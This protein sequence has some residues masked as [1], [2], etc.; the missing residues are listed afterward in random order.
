MPPS[1]SSDAEFH[2]AE[3]DGPLD[4]MDDAA[5]VALLE[6]LNA[7]DLYRTKRG[8]IVGSHRQT[9]E[10]YGSGGGRTPIP[11]RALNYLIERRIPMRR[12]WDGK[13]ECED[14]SCYSDSEFCSDG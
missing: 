13:W 3:N 14:G 11:P 9:G 4:E 7:L 6:L 5:G 12:E 8:E 1:P 2:D 10:N